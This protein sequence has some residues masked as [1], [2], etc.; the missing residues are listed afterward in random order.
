M[1]LVHMNASLLRIRVVH[2]WLGA[3]IVH[4]YLDNMEQIAS[5]FFSQYIHYLYGYFGTL[6]AIIF[7]GIAV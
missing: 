5:A 3:L 7:L 1:S 6:C 2:A 4:Q